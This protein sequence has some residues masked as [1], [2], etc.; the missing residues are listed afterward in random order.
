MFTPR[1][2]IHLERLLK[3]S[4]SKNRKRVK[5]VFN[6]ST[7]KKVDHLIKNDLNFKHIKKLVLYFQKTDPRIIY[8][9]CY[10][11]RHE[12]PKTCGDRL[13]IYKICG[14]DHHTNNY[15]YNILTY[16]ARKKRRYLYDL[17][18]YDNYINIS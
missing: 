12:K 15:I 10:K 4:Q 1:W 11:I 7:K 3:E 9:R 14:R 16:K 6:I 18:K 8:Y 5:I 2:I 13:S 17:I